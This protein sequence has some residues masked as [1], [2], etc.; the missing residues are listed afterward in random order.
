MKHDAGAHNGFT[1]GFVSP[2]AR[3]NAPKYL[4]AVWLKCITKRERPLSLSTLGLRLA[5]F[6]TSTLTIKRC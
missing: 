2:F 5:A 3:R 1:P 4:E 6:T